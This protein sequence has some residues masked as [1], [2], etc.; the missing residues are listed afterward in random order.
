MVQTNTRKLEKSLG[1]RNGHPGFCKKFARGLA[2]MTLVLMGC[3][4]LYAEEPASFSRFQLQGLF[5][6]QHSFSP[7]PA[8]YLLRLAAEPISP[9]QQPLRLLETCHLTSLFKTVKGEEDL[10]SDSS[11]TLFRQPMSSR[12]AYRSWAGLRT[13][14]GRYF[15]PE[16]FGRSRTNGAGIN[17]PDFL[18]VKMSFRF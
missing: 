9:S 5:S 2:G 7:G 11:I 15:S 3:L 17:E 6:E 18:Y 13:G 16:T 8:S 10:E 4:A 12:F 14:W 1:L